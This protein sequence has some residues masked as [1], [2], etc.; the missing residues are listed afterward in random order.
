MRSLW[1]ET[2]CSIASWRLHST[3]HSNLIIYDIQDLRTMSSAHLST[4][5]QAHSVWFHT[6]VAIRH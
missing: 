5:L 4:T 1:E 3:C 6:T 2:P